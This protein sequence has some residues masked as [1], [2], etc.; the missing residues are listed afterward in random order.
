MCWATP[1]SSDNSPI[2]S[3]AP[4]SFSAG[5]WSLTLRDLVAHY[6]ARTERHHAPRSD[7]NLDTRL[8][9][10]ADALPLVAKDE[11]AEAGNL[12]VLADGER[13][14]HVVQD[15]LDDASGFR[16]REAEAAMN[17]VGEI[18]SGERAV[19]VHVVIDPRDPEIGHDILP[20]V[21]VPPAASITLS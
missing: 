18:R 11:G 15:T 17:N 4:G 6:L 19:G 16:A 3:K 9:V 21:G 7:R 1:S 20:S 10:A 12:H 8:R 2:V 13:M 5:T 14:A